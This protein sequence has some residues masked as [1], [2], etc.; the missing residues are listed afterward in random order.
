MK[1]IFSPNP[2]LVPGRRYHLSL[3]PAG[4]RKGANCLPDVFLG[5]F[6]FVGTVRG[7]KVEHFYFRKPRL[8]PVSFTDRQMVDL[9]VKE[10][11]GC[12]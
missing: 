6:E 2:D 11:K 1:G 5:F 9:I 3:L 8:Q 4:A 12:R 7:M 10:A